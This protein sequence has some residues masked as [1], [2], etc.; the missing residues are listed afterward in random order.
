MGRRR[1]RG[2]TRVIGRVPNLAT[3]VNVSFLA[4]DAIG[5]AVRARVVLG[6]HASRHPI[7]ATMSHRNLG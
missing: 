7:S 6:L 3:K 4:A 2:K 5:R 1:G